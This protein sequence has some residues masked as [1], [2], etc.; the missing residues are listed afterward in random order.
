MGFILKSKNC[1]KKVIYIFLQQIITVFMLIMLQCA[2]ITISSVNDTTLAF[3]TE[4]VG[5]VAAC[6]LV[7]LLDVIKQQVG[8]KATNP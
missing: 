2:V 1:N 8:L 7:L 3:G 5:R 4:N 6:Q